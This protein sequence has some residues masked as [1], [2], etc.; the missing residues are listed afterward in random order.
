MERDVL[1][2][3]IALPLLLVAATLA[4]YAQTL[5]FAFIAFDDDRYILRNPAIQGGLTLESARWALTTGYEGAWQ[6]LTWMSFMVDFELFGL[7]AFASC[8]AFVIF[9]SLVNSVVE[10]FT[11]LPPPK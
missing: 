5:G 2:S 6:P 3:R 1:I 7:F 8:F 9:S 11:V 4:V 10:K